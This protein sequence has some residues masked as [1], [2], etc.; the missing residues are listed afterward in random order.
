MARHRAGRGPAVGSAIL[1]PAPSPCS[2]RGAE[3][4]NVRQACFR[5]ASEIDA[6]VISVE[7]RVRISPALSASIR[8][9]ERFWS[10]PDRTTPSSTSSTTWD[11]LRQGEHP[12][13][14]PTVLT[15]PVPPVSSDVCDCDP[16]HAIA[17]RAVVAQGYVVPKNRAAYPKSSPSYVNN[18]QRLSSPLAERS[19]DCT[20]ISVFQARGDCH[21]QEIRPL[22]LPEIHGLRV[23]TL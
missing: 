15:G 23:V 14:G 13:P 8:A 3:S 17:A 21:G 9:G 4:I 7:C 20:R 12:S 16:K 10:R 18:G 22:R 1:I 19:H 6:C 5:F 11:G 2:S